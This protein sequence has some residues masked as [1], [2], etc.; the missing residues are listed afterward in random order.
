MNILNVVLTLNVGGLERFLMEFVAN[1][2]KD[3]QPSVVCLEKKGALG[4][5]FGDV[6]VIELNKP[7]G[8]HISVANQ[9]AKIIRRIKVDII[10]THNP[11]PHFYGSLAGFLT[12]TPVIHTKHGRN[13]PDDRGELALA[14]ISNRLTDFIV[15]VSD[16]A[17]DLCVTLQHADPSKIRRIYNGIDLNRFGQ[18][19]I[20]KEKLLSLGIPDG[21]VTAG[22][23]AR[24]CEDKDH[25]T[26]VN[27]LE[28]IDCGPSK[29]RLLIIGDGPLRGKMESLVATRGVGEYVVFTGMRDDIPALLSELDFCILSTNTEGHSITLL[30][31][32]AASLPCIATAVGGNPEVVDDGVTGFLVPHKDPQALAGKIICL[33][34]NTELMRSMGDAG[35]RRAEALF[36]I[37]ETVVR[38]VECYRSLVGRNA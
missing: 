2:P 38:Y 10:H 5:K 11:A 13:R 1:L 12:R 33:A 6:P 31:A 26:L 37:R 3:I 34:K 28:Y 4:G 19:A 27:S 23:V 24:I 15:P 14:R 7:P 35:R 32:M 8:V 16:D 20:R 25:E 21:C 18:R 22:M 36:D 17:A 30:E 9:L 29:F